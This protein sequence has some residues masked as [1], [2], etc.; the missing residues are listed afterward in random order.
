MLVCPGLKIRNGG[1]GRTEE[2]SQPKIVCDPGYEPSGAEITCKAFLD[3]AAF[4]HKGA[5]V[6]PSDENS[7]LICKAGTSKAAAAA[8][9]HPSL[10][11]LLLR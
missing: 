6:K 7:P 2:K 4:F 10:M 8:R 11:S 9:K 5:L 1:L 3:R